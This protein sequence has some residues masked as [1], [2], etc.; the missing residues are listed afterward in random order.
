MGEKAGEEQEDEGDED[1]VQEEE[2]EMSMDI[3]HNHQVDEAD[4]IIR[5]IRKEF[6]EYQVKH[7]ETLPDACRRHVFLKYEAMFVPSNVPMWEDIVAGLGQKTVIQ[8]HIRSHRSKAT[9]KQVLNRDDFDFEAFLSA[10]PGGDKV[11]TI[12]SNNPDHLP[13]GWREKV[14]KLKDMEET[15]IS[16]A[17]LNQD[18]NQRP[19]L[20]NPH[21]QENTNQQRSKE[22]RPAKR[23]LIFTTFLLLQLCQFSKWSLDGTFKACP[24]LWGQLMIVMAKVGPFWIPVSYGLLPDKEKDTYFIFLEMM[25]HYIEDICKLKFQVVKVVLDYELAVAQAVSRVWGAIIRGCLFHFSQAVFRFCQTN[26]MVVLFSRNREFRDFVKMVF[27]LAH[28]PLK[29]LDNT[30]QMLRNYKFTSPWEIEG[31]REDRQ[32][33]LLDYVQNW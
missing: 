18:P 33:L 9:G 19:E 11:L 31:E 25:I 7:P 28:I 4:E 24:V 3:V 17:Y 27:G 16:E 10:V 23:I 21:R 22:P 5:E 2:D 12:D 1:E 6:I 26:Q 32:T 13:E 15:N 30:M 14:N 8:R 20:R 29:D